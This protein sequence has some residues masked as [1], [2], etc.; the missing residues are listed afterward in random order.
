MFENVSY[1]Y[2]YSYKTL[3]DL[4]SRVIIL[5]KATYYLLF[6]VNYFFNLVKANS[7]IQGIIFHKKLNSLYNNKLNNI[8]ITIRSRFFSN[9]RECIFMIFN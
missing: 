2:K 9:I 7:S 5:T 4:F 3:Y 8:K 6:F 1:S